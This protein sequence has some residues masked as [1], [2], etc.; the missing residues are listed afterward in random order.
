MTGAMAGKRCTDAAPDVLSA[1]R[2]GRLR[3]GE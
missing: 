3:S 2:M 1:D